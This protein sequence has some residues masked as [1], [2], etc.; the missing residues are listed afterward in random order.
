MI[1]DII[2]ELNVENGSNYKKSILEKHKD[3]ELL[4]KTLKMTYDNVVYT[5]GITMKNIPEYTNSNEILLEEALDQL[6]LLNDRTH[7][8]HS[9][10]EFLTK[11]LSKLSKNDSFV[12]EK[13]INRDLRINLGKS[14]INKIF[15]SLITKPPYMRCSLS[16]K[17]DRINYPAIVQL[18]ADGTY[19]SLILEN[20]KVT[21]MGRSG[22]KD[23]YPVFFDKVNSLADGVYIGELLL[24]SCHGT[25][26]RM[27]ANGLINSDVEQNDMYL[28]CWD[29]LTLEE[30]RNK[31]STKHYEDRFEKMLYNINDYNHE[32]SIEAIDS[33]H[34][35]TYEEAM[36]Y[37]SL[38]VQEGYEGAVLKNKDTPL[39]D[40]TSPTQIKLKE[41]AVS[42]FII[43]G[44]QE[45][46]GR[47]QGTL[48]AMFY[49]SSDGLVKGKMGGFTDATRKEIWDNMDE[50]MGQI[51]SV[52][53]N[54]VSKSRNKDTY[55]LMF[56]SFV[57]I[58]NDKE[59]A[60]DLDYIQKA[61]K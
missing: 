49:E 40:H 29:Y 47:L 25:K 14:Q 55:A 16:D 10:I 30:W 2:Q 6:E 51:V 7:T 43:T 57:E 4:K 18:K 20:G 58:R 48:G 37:Y 3:N 42:E 21:L 22:E 13:V 54:G 24:K 60:D 46:E 35:N 1:Y 32:Y 45:G 31:K 26:D 28:Q 34:V 27:K 61:L 53:Y 23:D 50:F 33:K 9:A 11:L 44:F 5:F 38:K 36:K 8:G 15:K 19:R 12:L 39:K 59:V 56:A 41:E 52:K 17:L